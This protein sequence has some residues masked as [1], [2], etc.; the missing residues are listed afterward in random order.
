MA[1]LNQNSYDRPKCNEVS[2]ASLLLASCSCTPLT[3]VRATLAVLPGGEF[4]QLSG[5]QLQA[6]MADDSGC[7]LSQYRD[8]KKQ[9]V[10][11]YSCCAAR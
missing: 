4:F 6:A 5:D 2:L 10:R 8:C 7:V 11:V 1:C 9:W 3:A